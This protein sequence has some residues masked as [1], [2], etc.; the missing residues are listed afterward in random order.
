MWLKC[1]Y[2]AR[3]NVGFLKLLFFSKWV[4]TRCSGFLREIDDVN[5]NQMRCTFDFGACANKRIALS[6]CLKIWLCRCN[7]SS[8][9]WIHAHIYMHTYIPRRRLTSMQ[10]F[11]IQTWAIVFFVVVESLSSPASENEHSDCKKMVVAEQKARTKSPGARSESNTF[12]AK[13][14][15]WCGFR[16]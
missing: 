12:C 4:K 11:A 16:V 13:R 10:L 6:M 8:F 14:M 15:N 9:G 3:K 2:M 1:E 5:G 7:K